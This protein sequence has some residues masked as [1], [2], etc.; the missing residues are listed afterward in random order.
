MVYES[1]GMSAS[2]IVRI[3]HERIENECISGRACMAESDDNVVLED[4]DR[5]HGRTALVNNVRAAESHS[6]I[7]PIV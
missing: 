3:G 6:R 1:N 4:T 2:R 5:I 7:I